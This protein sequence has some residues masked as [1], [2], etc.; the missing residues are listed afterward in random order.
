MKVNRRMTLG[1]LAAGASAPLA[2]AQT[3]APQPDAN[4]D[5]QAARES[6]LADAQRIAMTQLPR[7]T[8]PAFSFR[9]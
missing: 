9:A 7:A 1:L 3:P 8:E 4:A 5:F 2:V 6:L